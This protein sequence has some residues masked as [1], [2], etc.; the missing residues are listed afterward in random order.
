MK[1]TRFQQNNSTENNFLVRFSSNIADRILASV[2]WQPK[3][4]HTDS[5][6]DEIM[7]QEDVRDLDDGQT[8]WLP[9][10]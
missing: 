7:A 8:Y 9:E 3:G 5:A 4:Q 6:Q 1:K 2:I 10:G